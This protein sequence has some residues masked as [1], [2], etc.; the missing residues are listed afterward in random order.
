MPAPS[1]FE[2][3]T[4]V[5]EDFAD[6]YWGLV[7]LV[8][9]LDEVSRGEASQGSLAE[10]ADGWR[11]SDCRGS[12]TLAGAALRAL[13]YEL[14][15]RGLGEGSQGVAEDLRSLDLVQAAVEPPPQPPPS[16]H[17][18]GNEASEAVEVALLKRLREAMP[19]GRG[20]VMGELQVIFEPTQ[21]PPYGHMSVSQPSRYPT[22]E[23]LSRA[24][25]APGG[26]A[27]NLWMR[28]PKPEEEKGRQPNTVHLY[29]MP[30][31][32]LHG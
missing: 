3:P 12:A 19:N 25:R 26:T 20:F 28:L 16:A 18:A 13:R 24:A 27:P 32:E 30:P 4:G 23:E 9:D 10:R 21:G 22:Y 31:E 11:A 6:A 7:G 17:A 2:V 8:R 1:N 14:A 15:S 29:V 5:P